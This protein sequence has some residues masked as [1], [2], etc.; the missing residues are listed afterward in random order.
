MW[1]PMKPSM[2][3]PLF[4]ALWLS[5]PQDAHAETLSFT[6]KELTQLTD[7]VMPLLDLI[8]SGEG[9]Y[10]SVNRGRAGDSPG[11]W[12]KK[13]LG[14][15][16]T[17]MSIKEVR[18]HQGGRNPD[19]W[20]N[21]KK[22][23]ANLFA[24]GRYQLIPCTLQYTTASIEGL[25]VRVTY[26]PEVQDA[27]GVFL[28]FVKRPIVGEYLLGEHNDIREAGQE[29]AKEFASIPIQYSNGRC[30]RGQSYYCGDKAGNKAH[31]E[32]EAVNKALRQARQNLSNDKKAHKMVEHK[33]GFRTRMS[34]W[35]QQLWGKEIEEP[36]TL[37]VNTMEH[38][39]FDYIYPS[40]RSDDLTSD[41]PL[42]LK[43]VPATN[44][45]APVTEP[46]TKQQDSPPATPTEPDTNTLPTDAST[47]SQ[48]PQQVNESHKNTEPLYEDDIEDV[49]IVP[50]D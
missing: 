37:L 36:H 25:D 47:V 29:L 2:I 42:E 19:C 32:I 45:E 26:S 49:R 6:L 30:R 35:W 28:L 38:T 10:T 21:G 46:A 7:D 18:Q 24:V 17:E 50:K 43:Q 15:S 20:Y 13:H 34:L 23:K 4:L 39:L 9:D 14:K 3:A 22:G 44:L 11:D 40:D 12:P 5:L 33:L 48:P 27:F 31:I 1:Y 16:I 8:A 41:T